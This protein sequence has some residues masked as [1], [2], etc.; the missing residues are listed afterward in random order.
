[1]QGISY[2]SKH[3]TYRWDDKVREDVDA[4]VKRIIALLCGVILILTGF[5]E[6]ICFEM[7]EFFL[8]VTLLIIGTFLIKTIS[9]NNEEDE[10]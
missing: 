7:F 4:V 3:K 10:E 5:L 9:Y 1:M 6:V 2:K 8:G